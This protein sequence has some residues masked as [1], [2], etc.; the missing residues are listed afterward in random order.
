[1]LIWLSIS[2]TMTVTTTKHVYCSIIC[3][4]QY[5]VVKHL[6]KI[7]KHVNLKLLNITYIHNK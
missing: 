1:M 6:N 3:I 5:I 2:S 4:H 7:V